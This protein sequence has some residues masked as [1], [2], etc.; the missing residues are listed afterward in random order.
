[1]EKLYYKQISILITIIFSLLFSN[2]VFAFNGLSSINA[3]VKVSVCGNGVVEG[4]EQCESSLTIQ[5]NCSDLG[6][7]K[8]SLSCDASCSFVTSSCSYLPPNPILPPYPNIY[9]IPD[10]DVELNPN[11]Y[12]LPFYLSIYDKD[13]NGKLDRVE[14]CDGLTYWL[15]KWRIRI[16]DENIER[17]ITEIKLAKDTCDLNYDSNCDLIDLSIFLSAEKNG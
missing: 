16:L 4:D 10:T 7:D 9:N 3:T 14:Y 13:S 12:S 1:M 8:G 17:D 2:S 6:Y 15:K 11:I 5:E